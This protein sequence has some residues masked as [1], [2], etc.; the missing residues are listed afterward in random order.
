MRN[1]WQA[2]IYYLRKDLAFKSVTAVFALASLA[3]VLLLGGKGGYSLSSYAEPLK[4]AASFSILFYLVI[5]LHACFLQ[6]KA[7]SMARCRI[8]LLPGMAR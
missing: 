5:P 1:F 6:P 3:L 2:E 8:L 7:L 4:T